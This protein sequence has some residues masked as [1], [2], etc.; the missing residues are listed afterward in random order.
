MC[1]SFFFQCALG[2]NVG[3]FK[4]H[5][6]RTAKRFGRFVCSIPKFIPHEHHKK[7]THSL[8]NLVC[9]YFEEV[10]HMELKF[11]FPRNT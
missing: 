3:V 2:M 9:Y 8:F 7:V 11:E 4:Q 10:L 1:V 6:P 5:Y